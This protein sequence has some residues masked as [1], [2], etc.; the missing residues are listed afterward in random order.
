MIVLWISHRT[1][2]TVGIFHPRNISGLSWQSIIK[3]SFSGHLFFCKPHFKSDSTALAQSYYT[4]IP[5]TLVSPF[6]ADQRISQ[7]KSGSKMC[8]RWPRC[9]LMVELCGC[10]CCICVD[11]CKTV[12]Q[13]SWRMESSLE[14]AGV[15]LIVAH[16]TTHSSTSDVPSSLGAQLFR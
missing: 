16:S 4:L 10:V 11:I 8:E 3:G 1:V 12:W 2:C 6:T 15:Y 13:Y 9:R 5:D 7:F 14:G